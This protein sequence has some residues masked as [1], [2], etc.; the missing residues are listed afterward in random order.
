MTLDAPTALALAGALAALVWLIIRLSLRPLEQRLDR[1][2][3]KLETKLD[4]I[5]DEIDLGNMIDVRIA[6]HERACPKGGNGRTPAMSAGHVVGALVLAALLLWACSGCASNPMAAPAEAFLDTVG[7]EYLTYVEA[8]PA[9]DESA[10][11]ARRAN[12]QAFRWLV[13]EARK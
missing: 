10:K 8:D 4:Q 5:K 2:E 1:W 7:T 11:Q 13:E 12:V 3:A 6:R 9:L